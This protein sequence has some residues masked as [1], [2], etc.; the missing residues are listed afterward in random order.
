[1]CPST[2]EGVRQRLAYLSQ[3]AHALAPGAYAGDQAAEAE[4]RRVEAEIDRAAAALWD[5]SD[6]GL[7]GQGSLQELHG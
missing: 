6:A 2:T 7:A 5:L 3:R 1:L 4:L